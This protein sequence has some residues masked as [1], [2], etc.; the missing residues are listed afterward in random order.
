M[1]SQATVTEM[2]PPG[3]QAQS[4]EQVVTV[5]E[6]AWPCCSSTCRSLRRPPIC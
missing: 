6:G 4:P 2:V 1:G 5:L 3:F